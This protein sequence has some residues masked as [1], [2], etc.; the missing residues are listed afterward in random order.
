[1][2]GNT[3]WNRDPAWRLSATKHTNPDSDRSIFC[4]CCILERE[5]RVSSERESALM[6]YERIHKVQV[7]S[8]LQ[9]SKTLMC[10]FSTLMDLFALLSL[11]CK[12]VSQISVLLFYFLKWV[13]EYLFERCFVS[14]SNHAW[15]DAF[16]LMLSAKEI[17]FPSPCVFL[18]WKH[19]YPFGIHWKFPMGLCRLS[20]LASI[21]LFSCQ[22]PFK[23]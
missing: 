21:R 6:E 14:V 16:C 23:G 9:H 19:E 4:H 1:M 11:L 20:G 3:K 17:R 22:I 12:W 13:S 5:K 8:R 18:K 15:S 7:F 10:C 2:Q